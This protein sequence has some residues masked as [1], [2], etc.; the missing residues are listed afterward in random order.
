MCFW[1]LDCPHRNRSA[2]GTLRTWP[3][4]LPPPPHLYPNALPQLPYTHRPRALRPNLPFLPEL[5]IPFSQLD[6]LLS[7]SYLVIKYSSW[8]KKYF[9]FILTSYVLILVNVLAFLFF[10]I[11]FL[12]GLVLFFLFNWPEF[13]SC[14][15]LSACWSVSPPL[16]A[17]SVKSRFFLDWLYWY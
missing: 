7:T 13:W 8:I 15:R 14:F 10:S 11:F 6:T 1:R 17:P 12:I 4:I 3:C 5:H 9:D 16:R 2:I